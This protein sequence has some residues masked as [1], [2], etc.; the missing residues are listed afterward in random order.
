MPVVILTCIF[1]Q[2][3]IKMYHVV[4]ELYK[5]SLTGNKSTDGRVDGRTDSHSDHTIVQTH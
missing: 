5:F 1:M 2:N 4:Q 3:M